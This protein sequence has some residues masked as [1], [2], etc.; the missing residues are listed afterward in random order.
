MQFTPRA[1]YW[2]FF[3]SFCLSQHKRLPFIYRALSYSPSARK[4]VSKPPRHRQYIKQFL[5]NQRE[6]KP[7]VTPYNSVISL[8]TRR[9]TTPTTTAFKMAY[10]FTT[11]HKF[12]S[13]WLLKLSFI[14]EWVA[15][16]SYVI[17][18]SIY[19]KVFVFCTNVL[20]IY[21]HISARRIGI[22][23]VKIKT[24]S[25]YLFKCSASCHNSLA[26]LSNSFVIWIIYIVRDIPR[27]KNTHK[28]WKS[29]LACL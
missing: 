10:W 12:Q 28:S 8:H 5:V 22:S 16:S 9:K 14:Y 7:T 21:M 19:S 6:I 24:W 27:K 25:Y 2:H 3:F 18:L 23:F 4:R 11:A 20:K 1:L 17:V 26:Y 29:H 15:F 13:Q